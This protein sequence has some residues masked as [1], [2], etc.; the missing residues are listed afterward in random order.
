MDENSSDFIH[1]GEPSTGEPLVTTQE[2]PFES[3]P[4]TVYSDLSSKLRFYDKFDDVDVDEHA[5]IRRAQFETLTEDEKKQAEELLVQYATYN[6]PGLLPLLQMTGRETDRSFVEELQKKYD[7]DLDNIRVAIELF[8]MTY[9]L[10]ELN[11]DIRGVQST[12]QK[13]IHVILKKLEEVRDSARI[14]SEYV[15][16]ATHATYPEFKED[17]DR[18]QLLLK[19][20]TG[21]AAHFEGDGVYT[22]I[23]GSYRKWASGEVFEFNVFLADTFPII[24]N[25][26]DPKAMA[27]ILSEMLYMKD[28]QGRPAIA[29]GFVQWKQRQYDQ[30]PIDPWKVMLIEE[31]LGAKAEVILDDDDLPAIVMDTSEEPI[32]WATLSRALRIRRFIPKSEASKLPESIKSKHR[33]DDGKEDSLIYDFPDNPYEETAE[34][35]KIRGIHGRKKAA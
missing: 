6:D 8:R 20:D 10:W 12:D 26:N 29:H 30:D 9:R 35:I 21:E 3:L 25:Y 23:L 33:Y 15:V 22:G 13:S 14:L 5:R 7:L 24:V 31:L 17:I 18:D 2:L 19:S 16:H 27:N 34:W 11:W 1:P 32:V 28:H 4:D